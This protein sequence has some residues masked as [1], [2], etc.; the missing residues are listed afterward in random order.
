MQSYANRR[1][2]LAIAA[3]RL[4][5][6]TFVGRC[7]NATPAPMRVPL[8]I[9]MHPVSTGRH[10]ARPHR[11]RRRWVTTFATHLARRAETILSRRS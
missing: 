10:E 2:A 3:L 4:A 7:G 9:P 5:P 11:S 1:S 6:T 8:E